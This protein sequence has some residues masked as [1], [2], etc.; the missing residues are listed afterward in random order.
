MIPKSFQLMG[1]TI[2]VKITEDLPEH[3][4]GCWKTKAQEIHILPIGNYMTASN[5]EETFW[6]E[7]MHV[8]FEV[9]SY[10]EHYEDEALVDRIAQ[11]LY[12]IDKTKK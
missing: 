9:T 10:T 6:H 2:K 5:Q 3:C 1:H 12:Q 7:V 11:C 8:I 4:D